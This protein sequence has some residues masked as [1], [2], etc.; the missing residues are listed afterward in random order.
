MGVGG[1]GAAATPDDRGHQA[2]SAIPLLIVVAALAAGAVIGSYQ[3]ANTSI[4]W[5]LAS[6]RWI[7]SER[8]VPRADPFSLTAAGTPWLDHEWLFQVVAALADGLGGAEAL[9]ALRA[10]AVAAL[11]GTQ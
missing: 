7:L 2:H 1:P 11:A 3:I 8:A 5:H 6:G 4:G 10:L 9:V